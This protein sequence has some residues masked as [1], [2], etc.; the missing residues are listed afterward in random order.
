M[1]FDLEP[2]SDVLTIKSNIPFSSFVALSMLINVTEY[3]PLSQS[4]GILKVMEGGQLNP[5]LYPCGG[6]A[7]E[8]AVPSIDVMNFLTYLRNKCLL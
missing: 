4:R 6:L 1:I 2:G 7:C 3:R 8:C 5:V